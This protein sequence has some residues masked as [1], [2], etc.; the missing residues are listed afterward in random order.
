MKGKS[1]RGPRAKGSSSAIGPSGGQRDLNVRLKTAR[2]RTASS[3]R[4]LERQLN[5]PYVAAAKR[6]GYRSRA[7]Y[8][9]IEIDDKYRLL[10]PGGRVVDLGAAPGGWSQIAAERVQAV[11]GRG[12]VVA[13]DILEMEPVAGVE[14]AQ[15]DFMDDGAEDWLKSKLEGGAADVVLSDMAAPTV[16]HA[17]TDHLRIMNLAEA[18]AHFAADVL[19]PGGAFLCK[20]FQGGTE[21]DLLDFLRQRFSIVRHVKPPASRADSAELYVLA[22]G[23]KGGR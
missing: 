1:G 5:D 16:G 10:K 8:K 20:V 12:Q 19:A 4:W 23:F 13:I 9:L 6:A 22:T 14:L 18:A 2:K 21:R 11:A 7:A 3:Q 17:K 15:L